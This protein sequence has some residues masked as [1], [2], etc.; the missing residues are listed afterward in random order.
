[1]QRFVVA[2][3]LSCLSTPC[4]AQVSVNAGWQQRDGL[5]VASSQAQTV[6]ATI[7]RG[8]TTINAEAASPREAVTSSQC[9][10]GSRKSSHA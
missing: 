8:F 10:E 5:T 9:D 3:L 7:L 1:M 2:I 6:R 4:T